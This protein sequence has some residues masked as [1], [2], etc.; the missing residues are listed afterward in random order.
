[1][2]K[3]DNKEVTMEG[4]E[5]IITNSH[6]SL[7]RMVA[8]GFSEQERKLTEKIEDVEVRL[9]QKING[10]GNRID[11]LVDEK[12]LRT[13]HKKLSDRVSRL[14]IAGGLVK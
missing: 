12:V 2:R 6:E 11:T 3:K 10:L 8:N 7:A 1:M 4:I 13:E 14:E 5:K 9:G